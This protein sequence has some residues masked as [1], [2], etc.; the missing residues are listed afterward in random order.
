MHHPLQRMP[1]QR[2]RKN[3]QKRRGYLT[4]LVITLR[5]LLSPSIRNTNVA[6]A[7][8]FALSHA[9]VARSI[10][11]N[12]FG[13]G[14]TLTAIRLDTTVAIWRP[15]GMQANDQPFPQVELLAQA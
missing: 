14:L 15:A 7:G 5:L 3:T 1:M 13:R 9:R 4:L 11:F 8:R 10:R 12:S 6:W 2:R